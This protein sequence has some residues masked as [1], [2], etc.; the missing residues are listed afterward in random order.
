[1]LLKAISILYYLLFA[2]TPFLMSSNTSE[3]FEFNKMMF[4]YAVSLTVLILYAI[5]YVFNKPKIRLNFLIYAFVLFL[6]SQI[7]SSFFSIDK[8]SS[9]YGVYGRFNGGILSLISCGVLMFV[10]F[11][12]ISF[13]TVRRILQISIISAILVVLWGLPAKFGGDL[14]CLYF[15]NQL[16]NSCWTAQFQ[17]A[18]RMFSTIGQPNWLGAYLAVNLFLSLTFLVQLLFKEENVFTFFD[19]FRVLIKGEDRFKAYFYI[20][21]SA[22]IFLGIFF[23]GSRSSI[24]AVFL[25]FIISLIIFLSENIQRIKRYLL[26]FLLISLILI[27]SFIGISILS[28]FQREKVPE[29]LEITDSF[30]IR[31]IVWEGA[32]K[33][34]AK[35]PVLGTGPE[36]FGVSYYFVK[37]ERHNLTSEW[38]FVYNK[39]HNEFLHI[40]ATTGFVGFTSYL[41][42]ISLSIFFISKNI[43]NAKNSKKIYS[44]GIL[45]AYITILITNFFGFSTST[46]QVYLFL[47]PIMYLILRNENASPKA[48]TIKWNLKRAF[49]ILM[50]LFFGFYLY[51]NLGRYILADRNYKKAL[52]AE[53][54]DDVL[55]AV[56]LYRKAIGFKYEPTYFDKLSS[57]LAQVAFIQ[58][59]SSDKSKYDSI[60]KSSKEAQEIAIASSPK[61][62]LFWRTKAR[63]HYLY[64]QFTRNIS[65]LKIASDAITYTTF[66][67]PTDAQS[68]YMASVFYSILAKE[69]KDDNYKV[70]SD[71][72]LEEAIRLRPN[73][74]NE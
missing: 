65:D 39:A 2:V 21:A 25:S 42:L 36:T 50:I 23:T 10:F 35:Y 71:K 60:V 13:F 52:S 14:S 40:L 47:L 49:F 45:S 33:L 46:L 3:I 5:F 51:A 17:P 69:G 63:N 56:N 59:F 44:Y 67:A 41:F 20:F 27:S 72:A 8:H 24:I 73:L 62:I 68:Y 30:T 64:Y 74:T 70:K 9:F 4:V 16:T 18:Q 61:N 57:A 58:S 19:K 43:K 7:L 54:A 32:L 66:I 55:T 26:R 12:T 53:G 15:T 38:D 48:Q 28:I 22:F 34:A 1:M 29:H 11:Q 6:F 31:S 37:P